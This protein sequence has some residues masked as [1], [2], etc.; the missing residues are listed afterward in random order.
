MA[1]SLT[2]YFF[3]DRCLALSHS[4]VSCS[5][6]RSQFPRLPSSSTSPGTRRSEGGCRSF[7][8]SQLLSPAKTRRSLL[9]LVVPSPICARWSSRLFSRFRPLPRR[10]AEPLPVLLRIRACVKIGS[11]QPE[12]QSPRHPRTRTGGQAGLGTTAR[13]WQSSALRVGFN[14]ASHLETSVEKDLAGI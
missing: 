1:I 4:G 2:M 10:L 3:S 12:C 7:S 13:S 9:T 8:D 6:R 11:E 14:G 5:I